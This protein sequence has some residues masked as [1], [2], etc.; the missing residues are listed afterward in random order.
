MFIYRMAI[1]YV[2]I[3]ALNNLNKYKLIILNI[4]LK[5]AKTN[6][7]DIK[8]CVLQT[9]IPNFNKL[10]LFNYKTY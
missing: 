3:Y 5:N 6:Y 2:K 10:K 9:V 7:I 8:T 1:L 4:V